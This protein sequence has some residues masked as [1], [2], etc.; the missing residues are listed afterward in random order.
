MFALPTR[1]I[2]N[3]VLASERDEN[4]TNKMIRDVFFILLPQYYSVTIVFLSISKMS[5]QQNL[6]F[7]PTS[8]QYNQYAFIIH[9]LFS[10]F[11][12]KIFENV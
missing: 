7:Y 9:R 5:I 6:S 12:A 10:K 8:L 1:P 11:A 3:L 2:E 4:I